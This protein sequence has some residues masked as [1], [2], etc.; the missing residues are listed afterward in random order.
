MQAF[1]PEF[2]DSYEAD[3]RGDWMDSR[4]RV[5]ATVFLAEYSDYQVTS[6]FPGSSTFLTL[7]SG[8]AKVSGLEVESVFAL[9]A[10]SN[11]FLNLGLMDSKYT[12]LTDSA[13]AAGI[14]LELQRAPDASAQISLNSTMD[15]GASGSLGFSADAKYTSDFDTSPSNDPEGFVESFTLVNSQVRWTNPSDSVSVV[16][17]C[18]NCFGK[19]YHVHNPFGMVYPAEPM[20]WNLRAQYRC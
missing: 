3:I 4:L 16:A 9:A 15:L 2:L 19:E 1:G 18:S 13:Q 12:K 20:L 5:N 11:V 8:E 14:G 10:S 17:E 6:V 7:N